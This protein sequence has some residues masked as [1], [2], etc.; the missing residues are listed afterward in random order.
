MSTHTVSK[1][2]VGILRHKNSQLPISLFAILLVKLF[3]LLRG[4]I[5]GCLL[6]RLSLTR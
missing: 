5:G 1:A 3:Q 6:C 4:F 2:R